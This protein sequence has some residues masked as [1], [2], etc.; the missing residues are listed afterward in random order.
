MTSADG[1]GVDFVPPQPTFGGGASGRTPGSSTT[2]LSGISNG[3]AYGT[4]RR[5]S[6]AHSIPTSDGM[7]YADLSNPFRQSDERPLDTIRRMSRMVERDVAARKSSYGSLGAKGLANVNPSSI[8]GG[9]ELIWP[10]AV[11]LGYP[12]PDDK[13]AHS[14]RSKS[15]VSMASLH[16]RKSHNPLA[17]SVPSSPIASKRQSM[18]ERTPGHSP[19][20]SMR[21]SKTNSPHA[22]A[23]NL[24]SA[25]APS[26]TRDFILSLAP[27][28]GGYAVAAT[29]KGSSP[30][31][32][33]NA[34]GGRRSSDYRATP[35]AGEFGGMTLQQKANGMASM[36]GSMYDYH[37][38][39]Y[40]AGG[41]PDAPLQSAHSSTSDTN[42]TSTSYADEPQS[43]SSTS[44]P[45]MQPVVH[46]PAPVEVLTA[47]NTRPSPLSQAH[48]QQAS[49]V[50]SDAASHLELG[51]ADEDLLTMRR[52]RGNL[53]P[54]RDSA[55]LKSSPSQ[56]SP[57]AGP[58][59]ADGAA[60]AAAAAVN[61]DAKTPPKGR[62]ERAK[63]ERER[64][65]ALARKKVE[66]EKER[67]R[68]EKLKRVEAKLR[69]EEAKRKE[70]EQKEAA[71]IQAKEQKL[72]ARKEMDGR[73]KTKEQP[74]KAK[75]PPPPVAAS[76]AT[77]TPRG[78]PPPPFADSVAT[79]SAATPQ[80]SGSTVRGAPT[81]APAVTSTPGR[82]TS[83]V[84]PTVSK[85]EQAP[86]VPPAPQR[87]VVSS[88]FVPVVSERP[89]PRRD[90]AAASGSKSKSLGMWGTLRRKFGSA[91]SAPKRTTAPP[92]PGPRSLPGAA[93]PIPALP[94]KEQPV[95]QSVSAYPLAPA[96]PR[97]AD[98]NLEVLAA[99]SFNAYE[100][101][102]PRAALEGRDYDATFELAR[103]TTLPASETGSSIVS[104]AVSRQ[105][106]P[107]KQS[108]PPV[109]RTSTDLSRHSSPGVQLARSLSNV[110][111]SL[112]SL[113]IV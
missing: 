70:K 22:S 20:T 6:M 76:P 48:Q 75:L 28:E 92:V 49:D 99:E 40:R 107:P 66:D 19:A 17:K 52:A 12:I 9:Q 101:L 74:L 54:P 59:L 98:R 100:A 50:A 78:T 21:K 8:L 1:D 46:A 7:E 111:K 18:V 109:S 41:R 37:T 33:A 57:L 5:H 14:K 45:A 58:P 105:Q 32:A 63:Q 16:S 102:Q 93:Q 4:T 61:G 39:G 31:G 88:A 3:D 15:A 43:I 38:N 86:A 113:P 85:K 65:L 90:P 25:Y 2:S 30:Y 36:D 110:D 89:S 34:Y 73:F 95:Q 77:I 80:S 60:V 64:S 26:T 103:M 96:A 56:S 91:A 44:S 87:P 68:E 83:L 35:M 108:R 55:A 51:P 11:P 23:T 112:P 106:S 13:L 67:K 27:R 62:K 29:I 81:P 42:S 72:K 71:K 53:Q 82:R 84:A 94:T 10:T 79:L 47:A 97:N 24:A 104:R 69:K